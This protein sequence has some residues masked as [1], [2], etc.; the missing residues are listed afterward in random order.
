MVAGYSEAKI[1]KDKHNSFILPPEPLPESQQAMTVLSLIPKSYQ[2]Q[3]LLR[4]LTI[5]NRACWRM[6]CVFWF[7]FGLLV[8]LLFFLTQQLC[9]AP[10]LPACK[11]ELVSEHSDKCTALPARCLFHS[12]LEGKWLRQN[13]FPIQL[14]TFAKKA[15]I[16]Q[17]Y[18]STSI[19]L[20][21]QLNNLHT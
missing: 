15:F 12:L 11:T 19:K 14:I 13:R 3:P 4:R 8:F 6:F 21:F 2:R 5:S 17:M 1:H 18:L 16:Y 7:W 9:Q 20:I 10:N